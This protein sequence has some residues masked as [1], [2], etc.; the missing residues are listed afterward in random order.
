MQ[1][2]EHIHTTDSCST[3]GDLT[4]HHQLL[5]FLYFIICLGPLRPVVRCKPSRYKGATHR[6][7]EAWQTFIEQIALVAHTVLYY[8]HRLRILGP[9]KNFPTQTQS[10]TEH[11]CKEES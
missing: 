6:K 11:L 10:P 2:V 8:S 4:H 1:T 7:C 5:H 9:I 3:N